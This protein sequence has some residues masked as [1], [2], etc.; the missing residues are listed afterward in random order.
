MMGLVGN[1]IFLILIFLQPFLHAEGCL[2]SVII[3]DTFDRFIGYS[4]VSDAY[5]LK[6]SLQAIGSQLQMQVE[7]TV[8]DE[9]KCRSVDL[10]TW[11][12]SQNPTE[13]DVVMVLYSGHGCRDISGSSLP[14]L[15]LP[16]SR[17]RG[18]SLQE[19][20]ERF[21]CKLSFL[22]LDCCNKST[23]QA[24]SPRSP[25]HPVIHR[26]RRLA[27]L[28]HLFQGTRAAITM[29]GA[30]RG[31]VAWGSNMETPLG[32]Y[33]TTGFLLALKELAGN[34]KVTWKKVL[35]RAR[36]YSIK[37]SHNK[38]HPFFIIKSR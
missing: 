4:C 31:E 19:A 37:R 24:R 32:G 14:M 17:L 9:L 11:L 23:G 5:R 26:H 36:E 22:F 25:F 10:E 29:C 35:N 6:E 15:D 13:A 21:P 16:D 27:G 1:L 28:K 2:R 38:Q 34:T 7:V 33:L 12:N 8:L 3:A 20:L 30:K 18:A